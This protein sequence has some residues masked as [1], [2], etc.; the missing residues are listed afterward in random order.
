MAYS[1]KEEQNI[2][3][4]KPKQT[5]LQQFPEILEYNNEKVAKSSAA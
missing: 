3:V 1:V 5:I 4:D 2:Y